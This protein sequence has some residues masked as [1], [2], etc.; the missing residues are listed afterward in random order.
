MTVARN[1][2]FTALDIGS[3]KVVCFIARY[4]S[5][6]NLSII[7][8]GHQISQGLKAGNVVD[9]Q[10]TEDAIRSAI[11]SAERMAGEKVKDVVI[12]FSGGKF[13]SLYR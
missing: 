13:L 1:Q 7:G 3:S 6:N 5:Q 9:M 2:I 8:I 10:A 11:D 4:K 12:G